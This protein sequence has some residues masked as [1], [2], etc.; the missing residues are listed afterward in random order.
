M[1][2]PTE[3]TAVARRLV[4]VGS[5]AE[6]LAAIDVGQALGGRAELLSPPRCG[7]PFWRALLDAIS[8]ARPSQP[9]PRGWLDAGDRPGA[10]LEGLAAGCRAFVLDELTT[11]VLEQ[12][13]R[14]VIIHGAQLLTRSQL[15]AAGRCDVLRSL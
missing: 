1:L 6:A 12:L 4:R 13:S 2:R 10:V 3:I 9:P 11:A 14:Q 7:G 5:L 15:T 8:A